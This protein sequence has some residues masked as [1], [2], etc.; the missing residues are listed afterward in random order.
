[1]LRKNN[2]FSQIIPKVWLSSGDIPATQ[3]DSDFVYLGK[4]FNFKMNN[5][6]AKNAVATKLDSMLKTTSSLSVKPQSKI[7]I[8]YSFISAQLAFELKIYDFSATWIA[9]TLD[10][11][12]V[13]RVRDWIEA[14]ISSCVSEWLQMPLNKGGMG[15]VSFKNRSE[16]LALSTRHALRT[17]THSDITLL[18]S[19]TMKQNIDTDSRLL[20][21]IS[22]NSA[23]KELRS[24]QKEKVSSQLLGLS[25]QG[26]SLKM[27]GEVI[28]KKNISLWS[29]T[30]GTISARLFNF[31]LKAAQQQLATGA[32]LARW[33]KIQDPSC[34]L[35]KI[36]KPQT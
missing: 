34:A 15:I 33:R 25:Y 23:A 19:D 3:L 18:W 7:K 12:C 5:K 35:C 2:Q 4:I 30:V 8:L 14:P 1:M 22:Y 20:R 26:K 9:E 29:E 6:S 21:H 27:I 32:N 10:A 17:S 28:P 31:S 24:E 13:N 16:R 36:N 11:R